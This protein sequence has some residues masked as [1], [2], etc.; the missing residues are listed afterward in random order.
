MEKGEPIKSS[1]ADRDFQLPAVGTVIDVCGGEE[2]INKTFKSMLS[3]TLLWADSQYSPLGVP[4]RLLPSPLLSDTEGLKL[5]RAI[6]RLPTYYQTDGEVEHFEAFG[7]EIA[8]SVPEN[9]VLIDLGCGCVN[10]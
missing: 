10:I 3:K 8:K 6:I 5:M 7:L 9:A 2:G 4:Q 1:P